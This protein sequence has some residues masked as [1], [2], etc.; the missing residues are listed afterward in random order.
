MAGPAVVFREIHRWRRNAQNLQ[1]Q[2]ERIPRQLK[3][4]Q[5]RVAR[6]EEAYRQAQ[7]AIKRLKVSV[8]EKE[9]SLKTRGT[10]IAKHQK[11]LNEAESKKEYDALQA[12][13]AAERAECQ[14]LEDEILAGMEEGEAKAAQL[15]ELEK[16]IRQAKEEYARAE[17]E[18]G[19][20]RAGLEAQL[21]EALARLKEAEAT[22]PERYREQYRRTVNVKGADALAPVRGRTCS[23]CYT[24]I[25]VQNLTD[26]RQ[27]MFLTCKSCGR[28]LYLP[29]DEAPAGGEG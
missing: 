12:E 1:E 19:A 17:Q 14:R 7:E 15:P 22:I 25:T 21:Q 4:Q 3:A 13:V 29:E 10:Q 8:H 16:A 5:A 27:E 11:Q 6:H 23:A 9:V 24:E 2:L 28:L 20:R 26:L 18:A